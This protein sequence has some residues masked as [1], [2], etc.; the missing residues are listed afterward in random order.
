MVPNSNMFFSSGSLNLR[1]TLIFKML[2][3]DRVDDID[4]LLNAMEITSSVTDM[5]IEDNRRRHVTV[6]VSERGT[7]NVESEA[8]NQ[9]NEGSNNRGRLLK[10]TIKR[11]KSVMDM[12]MPCTGSYSKQIQNFKA[13]NI[14]QVRYICLF[15]FLHKKVSLGFKVVDI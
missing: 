1:S 11:S 7:W 4:R 3:F 6:L 12:L 9:N 5:I 8:R 15:F 14:K 2:H 10:R 13:K